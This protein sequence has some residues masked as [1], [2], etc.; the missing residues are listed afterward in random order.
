MRE[1]D[2]ILAFIWKVRME[3]ETSQ[4][5]AG[6]RPDK[7]AWSSVMVNFVLIWLGLGAQVC[8]QTLF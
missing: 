2:D 5:I 6:V 4:A 3:T 8:G 7:V 1:E